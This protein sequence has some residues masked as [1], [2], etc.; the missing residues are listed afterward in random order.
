MN[1][2]YSFRNLLEKEIEIDFENSIK[3]V[4]NKIEIPMIQRD[5]AQGRGKIEDNHLK[6]NETGKRFIDSVFSALKQDEFMEM[7]FVYGS[8][9]EQNQIYTFTPLDGQ[10]RLT[11]LFLLYWY[12]G[13]RELQEDEHKNLIK[14]LKKF[15]Y[16]TRTSSRRF[17]ELLCETRLSFEKS[18]S[19]EI[20]NL[21]WFFK[22]YKKDPTIKAMLNMLD[23]IDQKYSKDLPSFRNL[24]KLQFYILPLNGFSL[25]EDLYI[26][27]NARG[28][29]LTDF[30]N[31][32]A[33]LT[34]WMKSY[35]IHKCSS[36]KENC[37]YPTCLPF[38][39]NVNYSN[40]MLPYHLAISQKMDNEWTNYFWEITKTE[41][42]KLVDPLFLRFFYRYFLNQFI[43]RSK[44]ENQLSGKL[45]KESDFI[46][47]ENEQNYQNFEFF[48]NNLGINELKKI[49]KTLD[50]LSE[51]WDQICDSIQPS[52]YNNDEKYSFLNNKITQT[53]RVVMC[54]IILYIEK[55]ANFDQ[56]KFKQWMRVVWNIVEN[57]DI[58]DYNSA[59]GVMN[60][61]AELSS[62]SSSIYQFLSD[63][64]IAI[65]STS[66]KIAIEEEKW[67]SSFIFSNNQFNEDWENAFINAEKHGFFKGSVS[68]LISYSMSVAEFNNRV[69]LAE[70][71]FSEKGV[72]K[73]YRDDG[74]IFLRALI[75]RYNEYRQINWKN[76]TDTDE[77]EHYLKK[78]LASD[79]VI[80]NA[81]REWF[82]LKDEYEFINKLNEEVNKESQIKAWNNDENSLRRMKQIHENLYKNHDL[83]NIMH[84]CEAI[85]FGWFDDYVF[86][87]KPRSWYD[88][89]MIDGYRNE[90]IYKLLSTYQCKTNSQCNFNGVSIPFFAGKDIYLSRKRI[91]N[92]KEII[93]NYIFDRK[94][95]KV[96]IKENEDLKEVFSE[97]KFE[98]TNL[99]KGWICRKTFNYQKDVNCIEDIDNF[100]NKVEDGLTVLLL[101]IETQLV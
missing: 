69:L 20:N 6:L 41:E 92:D 44:T 64:E 28:K 51:Y 71:V 30:E 12:I 48:K 91:I 78:M 55:N 13:L 53:Q 83:Q 35:K 32:K 2:K 61:L 90:I 96:G 87:S 54:G 93:F 65:T 25:T 57:T 21:S 14:L 4:F 23:V 9:S 94:H 24:E 80:R 34:K 70:K 22:S 16:S 98:E 85:R 62:N 3:V 95:L 47:F 18:P 29:Q 52:W 19:Q 56:I 60:L 77:S 1:N 11:T 81:T 36:P 79:E 39:E 17:C 66:S 10:Q 38:M 5:Y 46:F 15:T 33:D 76:F 73:K 99:E 63:S 8:I 74:H 27:M 68:F 7:D 82:S 100:L 88:W 58:S 49:E 84:K 45:E 31:F 86:V 40:R 97:I 72:N 101:K 89:I 59:V 75:S 26:K 42:N 50:T 67:K 37:E 43:L